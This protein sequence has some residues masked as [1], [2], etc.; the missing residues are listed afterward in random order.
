M[1]SDPWNS[2]QRHIESLYGH[3][4][5]FLMK[6]AKCQ[7]SAQVVYMGLYTYFET[8]QVLFPFVSEKKGVETGKF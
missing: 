3:S 8:A 6:S 1:L 7:L 4:N 5:H 2:R